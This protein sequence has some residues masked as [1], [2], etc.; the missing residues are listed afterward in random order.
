MRY[1][2]GYWDWVVGSASSLLAG[3]TLAAVQPSPAAGRAWAPGIAVVDHHPF[4]VQGAR[5]RAGERVTAVL[6]LGGRHTRTARAGR[7]GAF[8]ARFDEYANLCTAYTLRVLSGHDLR[9]AVRHDPPRS[10]AALDPVR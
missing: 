1:Q 8:V 2:L 9:A 5:F 6:V 4:T 7:G 3:L 10:C